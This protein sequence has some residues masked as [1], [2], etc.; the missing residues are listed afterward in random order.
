M[1]ARLADAKTYCT[2]HGSWLEREDPFPGAPIGTA[3]CGA[4]FTAG[5][6]CPRPASASYLRHLLTS[7]FFDRVRARPDTG[8]PFCARAWHGTARSRV[9]DNAAVKLCVLS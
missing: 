1:R 4:A 7:R 9:T 8:M 2:T 5:A 3:A 6:T